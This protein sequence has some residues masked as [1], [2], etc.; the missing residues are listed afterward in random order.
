MF[1]EIDDAADAE[2][3]HET[4]AAFAKMVKLIDSLKVHATTKQPEKD[5][6]RE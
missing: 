4:E 5:E 6:L 3:K 1:D 2:K